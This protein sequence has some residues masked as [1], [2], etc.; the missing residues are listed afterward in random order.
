MGGKL[1]QGVGASKRG[2]V[3]TPLRTMT[4]WKT[5]AAVEAPPTSWK[6]KTMELIKIDLSP[7][8]ILVLA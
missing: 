1:G 7:T 3:G 4:N 5:S 8:C 6:I 2:G